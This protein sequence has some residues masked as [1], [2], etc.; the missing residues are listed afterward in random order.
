MAKRS[1]LR[2]VIDTMVVIRGARALR[3]RPPTPE[4]PELRIILGWIEEELFDWLYSQPILDEYRAV[5]QRLRAPLSAAGR[6]INLLSEAGIKTEA[7]EEGS[8]SPDPKD[9]PFFHCGIAGR[10]DYIVTDNIRD[11]PPIKGRKRPQVI[12]PSEAAKILF[13]Y[14]RLSKKLS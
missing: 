2:L 12:T 3:Q 1:R 9:D 11:F 7:K 6:F 14:Y 8:F 10:A 4:T 5:L 13:G